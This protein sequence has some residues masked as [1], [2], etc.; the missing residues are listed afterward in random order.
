MNT[1]NPNSMA[2]MSAPTA[3]YAPTVKETEELFQPV[4]N[5]PLQ[6]LPVYQHLDRLL[7]K[8]KMYNDVLE[9]R[10]KSRG[11]GKPFEVDE[12]VIEQFADQHLPSGSGIDAGTKVIIH[13]CNIRQIVL[14]CG[15]HSMDPDNGMYNGWVHFEFKLKASFTPPFRML[16][17]MSNDSMDDDEYEFQCDGHKE[18]VDD[19]MYNALIVEVSCRS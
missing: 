12:L 11:I 9:G 13:E 18:Y 10:S 1:Y 3:T 6:T 5:M 7:R 8:H 16:T 15:Y 17:I 4:K 19:T 14:T 2:L